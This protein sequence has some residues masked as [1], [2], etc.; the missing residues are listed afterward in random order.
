MKTFSF[1]ILPFQD[2]D[3]VQSTCYLC[4]F[5]F[6]SY[7]GCFSFD[8]KNLCSGSIHDATVIFFLLFF[9]IHELNIKIILV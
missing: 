2:Q 6:F 5:F 4:I 8:L 1:N 9:D 3:W 7:F